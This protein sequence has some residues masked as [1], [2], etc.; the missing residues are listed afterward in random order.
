MLHLHVHKSVLVLRHHALHL[1]LDGAAVR[2]L[3]REGRRPNGDSL[4]QRVLAVLHLRRRSQCVVQ[5]EDDFP[6]EDSHGGAVVDELG[7]NRGN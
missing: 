1:R 4:L 6:E 5:R 3:W 7:R 2:R